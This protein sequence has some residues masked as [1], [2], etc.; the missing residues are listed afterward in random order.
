MFW[1]KKSK[2]R[3]LFERGREKAKSDNKKWLL[4]K[5]V[6]IVGQYHPQWSIYELLWCPL[7]SLHPKLKLGVRRGVHDE[8]LKT[9][10][11]ASNNTSLLYIFLIQIHFIKRG[12]SVLPEWSEKDK[13]KAKTKIKAK[14]WYR[15]SRENSFGDHLQNKKTSV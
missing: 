8:K 5:V 13:K 6:T 7:F 3:G 12:K 14:I 9:K 1:T 10:Q 2:V 11:H 15:Q 4:D